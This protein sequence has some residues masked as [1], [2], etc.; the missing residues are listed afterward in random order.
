MKPFQGITFCPTAINNEIL[1]KKIS[2]KIIKLGG[3][4]SKDLTRQVNVLVVGSTTNTNKFK[5]AVKHRFDI[6]FIDIQAI[7]DI[8]QLWLSGENILPDSNTATMTGSTYEMLK[9]LYRRFSFK[10]LHNFNIFIGRITDT[11]ITSIDSLVRSIKKLGCSSYNY[12]NFVI[13]DTSSHNDDDDQGQNGQI[14]IFVTDTLLGARVNAA[15]EQN[16]PIVHFKWILDCQKRS[17]LLPYDP[18]YLLPNIKDLPY[19][20]IGSNS[21]DCWDKINTTFPTNIDAQSSLQ[22][23][24]SSSTLTPSLPKTSSLLNKFK[25]KGE[26]I[27]DKAMSL[28]QH[29]KTNF[30]V[31]GQ[32]PLSINNKQEDL[33]DNSTLIFKN[34]AFIIHH[35]FPG[36]H[37]SILTKIVVQNGGKIETS[38]LSGIYD[39]SY[40]IIPSNKTLDSFND[41]P[42][43]IDD[44]DGIVTEFF[45]ERCLYYQKLLH[46]IDLWSKPFLSTIEFQVSSSSKLLHHEFS[47]SPFLNVTITGFSG[48]ELLHLTKVL[49]LLKPMGINYV[50]YLNKS[51]D[52]LLINLAALPSIPKTH[53]L[54]SN[55]FSDLFTQ[56]YINNNNDDPGDN[57]RKDF[58]NNSILRN[59]MK[60]KIE[61]IKKFHS[62]PVVTPAFI[63]KLLSAASGE[64]N[65]IFLNNI[66]WCIICPRGHKD[67]FKC[68]IK[69]PYYTSI[70]SEKKYQNNDPKI[71]KTILLKRNNSSLSEHSMKD[72]K[73]E[74]LQKIRETDSGRKKRSVSSSIMDV[75]SERQMPDTK[76]IKLESLPKNFVP[77]QIKR[78]TSWGTIMSENVPTEQPTAISNPEEIPRTEEV[79]H[80]QVT[81]GSIQDKKRTASLEK[82]MR[83]QTRNQ[84]KELDS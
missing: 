54:W 36:N 68:K 53:P 30:S 4:F 75:S 35:I 34:C 80:T 79:S 58:Q 40:Y 73:N 70:S 32:S 20:S 72:T 6:I 12:Q 71:D 41:L 60:R 37:R 28:Q 76:R 42:E 45:I 11:N 44:N 61:Y 29:S 5:F 56:F 52:I 24:Q 3:I 51:T 47:S 66:K 62:I 59:S 7:D 1:A 19:D 10:Y 39:H 74:L 31:L 38:Y 50:E 77:K 43:I 81:Y 27:W 65:E 46:P 55:E 63:F 17:A 82:P 69:K 84:T 26:K 2:K 9:I 64:H 22:R 48:V 8:Y 21:C 15:I 33:S 49:N 14:S 25:P 78:T 23:Q 83:R 13:K 67:D 18:Y 16:I 57:N